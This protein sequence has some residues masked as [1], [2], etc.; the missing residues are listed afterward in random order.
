MLW[1]KLIFTPTCLILYVDCVYTNKDHDHHAVLYLCCSIL[2]EDEGVDMGQGDHIQDGTP[3]ELQCPSYQGA[4]VEA[5]EREGVFRGR[6]E[7]LDRDGQL[8]MT[9]QGH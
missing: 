4:E 5:E 8:Q 6:G 9:R 2:R 3:G 1:L 7:A